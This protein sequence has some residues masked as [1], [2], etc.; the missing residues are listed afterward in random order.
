MIKIYAADNGGS[1]EIRIRG[2]ACFSKSSDIVCAA[3]SSLYYALLGSLE[4]DKSVH[5]VR[6]RQQSGS[7]ALEFCA[8]KLT[9]G[10]YDMAL[11]GFS[12]L[13]FTYPKNVKLHINGKE[14][15][16]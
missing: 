10:A 1:Y 8:G 3:V 15:I 12:Q 11:H 2:H 16:L 4:N 13:A 5:R 6:S 14:L 7:A 9:A